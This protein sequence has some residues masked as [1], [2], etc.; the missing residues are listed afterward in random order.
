MK[1]FLAGAMVLVAFS[2]AGTAEELSV[3][4]TSPLPVQPL[5]GEVDLEADV[6]PIEQVLGVEFFVDG[7]F[8][9]RLQEPPFRLRVDVGQDNAEH[10]FEV[11][12]HGRDG[13][14]AV[15]QVVSPSLRIDLQVDLELQQLYVTV[16]REQLPVLDLRREE[17]V[18]VDAGDR[19]EL[20]TFERGDVP[21]TALLLVDASDSMRGRPLEA[22][23][24]GARAFTAGMESLDL[25]KLLLFSDRV[26]HTSPLTG[27]SDVLTAGL[28]GVTAAGGTALNDYLYLSLKLLEMRQGRRVVVLLT[29]GFDVA[30]VLSIRDVL[31]VARRSRALVYW[32]RL[33]HP[34]P[35]QLRYSAWRDAREHREEREGLQELVDQ[36]Y[37]S[38]SAGDGSW[39]KVRVRVRRP[40]LAVRTRQGYLDY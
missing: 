3:I 31:W 35:A 38:R 17:F 10:R 13:G 16:S 23:L 28:Q 21:L 26:V 9:G 29:D 34:D 2:A 30:S 1:R 19:Q 40:G 11:V 36:S 22:A 5:F 7:H 15:A 12:A 27:F 32:I 14:T 33:G 18:V 6:V 4:L 20:V 37:P 39:H 24:R 8:V 25:A